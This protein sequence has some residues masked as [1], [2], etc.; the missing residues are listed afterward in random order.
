MAT[1]GKEGSR[2]QSI[3]VYV[4]KT[5]RVHYICYILVMLKI[6]SILFDHHLFGAQV[7]GA[8]QRDA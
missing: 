5:D 8:L 1:A 4:Y 2:D 7:A 6:Y 3:N